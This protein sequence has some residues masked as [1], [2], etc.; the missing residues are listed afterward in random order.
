MARPRRAIED[1]EDIDVSQR[2]AEPEPTP[3]ASA[4]HEPPPQVRA[5]IAG[6]AACL[7]TTHGAVWLE[8][9]VGIGR[10][11][12]GS[13]AALT[14]DGS[15][16]PLVS[17]PVPHEVVPRLLHLLAEINRNATRDEIPGRLYV[18]SLDTDLVV[19]VTIR[20]ID[21]WQL[22]SEQRSHGIAAAVGQ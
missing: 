13:L 2:Q 10:T 18:V 15:R 1:M 19:R 11:D 6:R 16:H 8:S 7:V 4:D 14:S 12:S 3:R 20:H 5:T 21:T 22:L 9:V 17:H